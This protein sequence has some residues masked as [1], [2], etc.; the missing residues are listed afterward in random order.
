MGG[1]GGGATKMKIRGPLRFMW[2][3]NRTESLSQFKYVITNESTIHVCSQNNCLRI[4]TLVPMH[5]TFL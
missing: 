4:M 2:W 1:G 3:T 5:M